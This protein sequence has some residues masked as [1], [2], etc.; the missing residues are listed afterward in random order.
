MPVR[1]GLIDLSI[2]MK[3]NTK[4]NLSA[5]TSTKSKSKRKT[6]SC[7]QDEHPSPMCNT[8]YATKL[9]GAFF[10]SPG[11]SF[12]SLKT[13]SIPPRSQSNPNIVLILA[14]DLGYGDVSCY[15]SESKVATPHLDQLARQGMRFTDAHSPSTVCTPT[16]Y[17]VLTGRMAFR[18]GY[19]G[20]F[21]G[22]GGPCLI[23]KDRLT[24]AGMLKKQGYATAMFG[25][26]HIG[27]TFEDAAGNRITKGGKRRGQA[28]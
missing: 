20:V 21:T 25:K 11:F 12:N 16:R 9:P 24:L 1:R 17:S 8:I 6:P 22:I 7:I 19:R 18:T 15:N 5:K 2:C 23:E 10:S 14:D 4:L 27:L 28:G 26:W 13:G 3:D